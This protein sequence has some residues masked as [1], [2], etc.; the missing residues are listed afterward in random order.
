VGGDIPQIQS[1]S[2]RYDL[3]AKERQ[4]EGFLTWL[5]VSDGFWIEAIIA[6]E[7]SSGAWF[8]E[9]RLANTAH[10]IL[11]FGLVHAN[12]RRARCPFVDYSALRLNS[13]EA[14]K[15][16]ANTTL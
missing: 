7:R 5:R 9:V 16:V 1:S 11:G 14:P 15:A 6:R 8:A 10:R 12:R 2:V 4:V 13:R 3:V